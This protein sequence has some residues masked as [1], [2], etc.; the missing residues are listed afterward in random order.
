M[1]IV[2]LL[3]SYYLCICT[4][5]WEIL[6]VY[7]SFSDT[8]SQR[9][10]I[11]KA[12]HDSG[13]WESAPFFRSLFRTSK[14]R[15]LKIGEVQTQVEKMADEASFLHHGKS[16]A[17][18]RIHPCFPGA[19]QVNPLSESSISIDRSI[20]VLLVLGSRDLNTNTGWW[21]G[22]FFI[23]PYIGNNHPNWLIFFRGV[24]TTNQNKHQ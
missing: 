19:A 11:G 2:L 7:T 6:G 13:L 16:M 3:Y 4:Y 8:P 24:Q 17:I 21:F 22:T 10:T 12:N 9:N 20:L 23:F 14:I 1:V 5:I 18:Q 15:Q